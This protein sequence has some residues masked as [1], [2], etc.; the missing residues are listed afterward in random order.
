MAELFCFIILIAV[1]GLVVWVMP[2]DG[3]EP[4]PDFQ[5]G[6][7]VDRVLYHYFHPPEEG[8]QPDW[9]AGK[10]W[11]EYGRRMTVALIRQGIG[12]LLE[13]E[14]VDNNRPVFELGYTLGEDG[15]TKALDALRKK[16]ER[17]DATIRE[18]RNE[19]NQLEEQLQGN[20]DLLDRFSVAESSRAGLEARCR[21]LLRELQAEREKVE[22][23]TS[24]PADNTEPASEPTPSSSPDYAALSGEDKIA[25]M[26][27]LKDSGQTYAQ[28]AELFGMTEGGV[29]GQISK[30]RKGKKK[31]DRVVEIDFTGVSNGVSVGV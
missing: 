29:K 26:V 16:V 19:R 23:L 14:Y 17:R 18:L 7:A 15:K 20:D 5:Q 4:E 30:A 13:E 10:A 11:H 31:T 22:A 2:R 24:V 25:T 3:P 1:L 27:S 8:Q 6:D 21:Q 12:E 28:I 9:P